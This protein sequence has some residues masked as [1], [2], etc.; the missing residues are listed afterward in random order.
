[1]T[2]R[3]VTNICY[4]WKNRPAYPE[5]AVTVAAEPHTASS[6]HEPPR[7]GRGSSRDAWAQHLTVNGIPV[8][9]TDTR[10]DLIARWDETRQ[11]S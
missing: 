11:P 10:D 4:R 5:P 8:T 7:A 6:F 1:M 9:G 2:V 3:R